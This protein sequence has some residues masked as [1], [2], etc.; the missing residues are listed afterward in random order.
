MGIL[1]VT[2]DSFSDGGMYKDPEVAADR[3]IQMMSEGA[4]LIDIGGESTRPGSESVPLREE[5][6]RTIPVIQKIQKQSNYLISIDTYK[7]EVASAALD[8]GAN[9]I[10]DI[11]GL[12]FDKA[13]PQLVAERD[14]PVILMHIKGAPKDM[15]ESPH[16]N[17]LILEISQFFEEQISKAKAIG[18][19][20]EKII[21]D[22]GIGF[23]KRFEDNFEII[24]EL[25]QICAMGY[26]VLLGPS[27]KS[28]IGKA[29]CLP[30]EERLEG[31]LASI[32]AGILNGARIV[33]VHDVKEARRAV[34]IAEKIIGII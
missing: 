15:Q 21:L 5:L 20:V 14:C 17:D 7:S 34:T 16:Y 19:G 30:V 24:R 10:N 28:F 33:R 29:L 18:I 13:M 3:A 4:D 22:P 6:N 11:S 32:T 25:G 8:T 27:R 31:T 26:P 12:T 2:P 23:G 9:I 1:N